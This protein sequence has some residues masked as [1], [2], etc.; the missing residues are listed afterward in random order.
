M[1]S[2]CS[3]TFSLFPSLFVLY[4]VNSRNSTWCVPEE[5]YCQ[6]EHKGP[7]VWVFITIG[8]GRLQCK[9]RGTRLQL[10]SSNDYSSPVAWGSTGPM[11]RLPVAGFYSAIGRYRTV[12]S[13]HLSKLRRC[14]YAHFHAFL[15]SCGGGGEGICAF[16]IAKEGE[17]KREARKFGRRKSENKN[18]PV[19]DNRQ[20]Q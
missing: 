10:S 2:S 14:V 3:L 19:M 17:R 4:N 9:K 1:V 18:R 12:E 6:I 13:R 8:G 5:G 20:T 11:L 16:A 7:R 15:F